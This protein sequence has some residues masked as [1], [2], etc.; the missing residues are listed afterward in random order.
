MSIA[1]TLPARP[2][3]QPPGTAL[4]TGGSQGIGL[5][6][7]HALADSGLRFAILFRGEAAGRAAAAG[8][9]EGHIL[10]RTDASDERLGD[11]WE[12]QRT[13]CSGLGGVSADL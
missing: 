8:L 4:V 12:L 1:P 6:T 10:I 7:A 5:A 3:A 9:G 13:V 2:E 11:L